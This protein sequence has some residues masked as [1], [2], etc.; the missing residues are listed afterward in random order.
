M[1]Q[2]SLEVKRR[3]RERNRERIA[4]RKREHYLA[5]RDKY[6]QIE[7]DRSYQKRY[8]ITIADYERMLKE[9]DGKCRICSATEAGKV[10]QHF[11][12]DHCHTTGRVRG[13]L[14][15]KCNSRLGWYEAHQKAVGTY[16]AT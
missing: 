2:S 1:S 13:L 3:Y 14:C 9:Q 4:Q 10:G 5:N 7:R 12:V 15:I 8:G 6:L 11:A 16:L